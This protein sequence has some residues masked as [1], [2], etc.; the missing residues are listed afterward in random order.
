MVVYVVET[1]KIVLLLPKYS[2]IRPEKKDIHILPPD[3]AHS[4]PTAYRLGLGR[5][6]WLQ[7]AKSSPGLLSTHLA[8]KKDQMW[9]PL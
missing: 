3:D 7:Q 9:A 5:P 1:I 4:T 8:T 6:G 2:I